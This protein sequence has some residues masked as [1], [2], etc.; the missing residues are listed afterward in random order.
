MRA[1]LKAKH[2]ADAG[3]G[4]A[5][6]GRLDLYGHLYPGDMD[7]GDDANSALWRIALS[8]CIATRDF[9]ARRTPFPCLP[10]SR[11]TSVGGHR[12]WEDQQ[13]AAI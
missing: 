9:E 2:A 5:Q 8:A 6:R 1:S 12:R 10:S 7:R 4:P 13:D 3:S 11:P